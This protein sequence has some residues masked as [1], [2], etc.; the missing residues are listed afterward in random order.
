MINIWINEL[1]R[2]GK[3]P[4]LVAIQWKKKPT[5][6]QSN[7]FRGTENVQEDVGW[8]SIK[9]S[10]ERIAT[11]C[12]NFRFA[13]KKISA[14]TKQIWGKPTLYKMWKSSTTWKGP[15]LDHC[16]FPNAKWS[17]ASA[18]LWC[19]PWTV[20]NWGSVGL[21]WGRRE[22]NAKLFLTKLLKKTD[23][24][25]L[26]GQRFRRWKSVAVERLWSFHIS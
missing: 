19:R 3:F 25:C 8:L 13:L 20:R 26:L 18:A 24:F 23:R 5:L 6:P 1:I 11:F 10:R 16:L 22:E 14:N 9:R 15:V 7:G 17:M 4:T 21:K 12:S 2:R